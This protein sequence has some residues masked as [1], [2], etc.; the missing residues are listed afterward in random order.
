MPDDYNDDELIEL[1]RLTKN[2]KDKLRWNSNKAYRDRQNLQRKNRYHADPSQKEKKSISRKKFLE[3]PEGRMQ[4]NFWVRRHHAKKNNIDFF[5]D[6]E[7]LLPLPTYC[8]VL[9]IEL[10]YGF[11]G[12][13]AFN[14]PSIDRVNPS[15]GYIKGNVIVISQK[16]NAIKQNANPTE[17]RAVADFFE[18]YFL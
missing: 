2:E 18:R 7:D 13:M 4:C 14:S 12:K 5:I 3:T 10:D 11:K 17:I 8:P 6:F 1:P 16:A 9:N 15:K